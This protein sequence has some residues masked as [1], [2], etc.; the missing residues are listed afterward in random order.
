MMKKIN[1]H[2]KN[3]VM[4]QITGRLTQNAAVSKLSDGREVARFTVALNNSYK[5][6]I[7][8]PK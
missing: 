5:P 1:V 6:T 3:H 7:P 4:Q 8:T 2:Q